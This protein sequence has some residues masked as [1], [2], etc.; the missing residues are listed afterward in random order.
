MTKRRGINLIEINLPIDVCVGATLLGEAKVE[1]VTIEEKVT[2]LYETLRMPVCRYL[3]AV[4]GSASE[5]EELAQ[6][7][8]LKLY[9]QLE[10]DS[11]SINDVRAWIFRVAHNLAVDRLKGGGR[12]T[13]L[14]YKSW[15]EICC[16]LPDAALN[17]EQKLLENERFARLHRAVAQLSPQ[18]RQCLLLRAEGFRYREIA[19]ILNINISSVA[20]F[21][22]RAIKR[23]TDLGV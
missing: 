13:R 17:P 3:I 22:R 5:A 1:A 21:I 8:F 14:D 12:E 18:Q 20:E 16:L 6:E 19:E 2:Q 15:D 23:I 9:L 11:R 7:A 4:L 10:R